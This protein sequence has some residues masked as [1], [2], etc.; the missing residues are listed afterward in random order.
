MKL[1]R[2]LRESFEGSVPRLVVVQPERNR[3][4]DLA[5]AEYDRLVRENASPKAARRLANALFPA[6]MTE[7]IESGPLLLAAAQR[8]VNSLQDERAV[9]PMEG[10]TWLA[11]LDPPL[12]RDCL[13]FETHLRNS[14]LK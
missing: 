9:L 6:S 2:I 12:M 1:G 14:F 3:V 13:V 10:L 11:P 7:A 4:I 5:I 8:S